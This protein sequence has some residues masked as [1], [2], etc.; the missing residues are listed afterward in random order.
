MKEATIITSDDSPDYFSPFL[1]L[2]L[3][4]VFGF[5]WTSSLDQ[6]GGW[7]G[8]GVFFFVVILWRR[9]VVKRL[10][11]EDEERQRQQMEALM[12]KMS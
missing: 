11:E 9:K 2:S 5:C 8:V 3:A 10:C 1:L 6:I 7:W 12:Q 4:T